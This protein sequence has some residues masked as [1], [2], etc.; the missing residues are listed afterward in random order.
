ME[1]LF[2]IKQPSWCTSSHLIFSHFLFR[3]VFFFRLVFIFRLLHLFRVGPRSNG[4]QVSRGSAEEPGHGAHSSAQPRDEDAA[5][6]A[7]DREPWADLAQVAAVNSLPGSRV[8]DLD[9]SVT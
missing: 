2:Q 4:A 1:P 8:G 9:I 7:G 5:E 3:L 6:R